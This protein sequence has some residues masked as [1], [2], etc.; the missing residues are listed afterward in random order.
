CLSHMYGGHSSHVTAVDFLPD[1]N[2]LISL[3]G[4]D[5]AVLQWA[6]V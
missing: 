2:R 1:D 4:R 5:C 6:V 3:G